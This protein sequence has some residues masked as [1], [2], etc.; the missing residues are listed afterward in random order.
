MSYFDTLYF[1]IVC[2]DLEF[3]FTMLF[4][5]SGFLHL[6]F[7]FFGNGL[8]Y[9]LI[10]SHW[11]L[12]ILLFVRDGFLCYFKIFIGNRFLCYFLLFTLFFSHAVW[13]YFKNVDFEQFYC[14][15]QIG[16]HTFYF[17]VGIESDRWLPHAIEKF[18]CKIQAQMNEFK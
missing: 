8:I 14:S 4:F 12:F 3:M 11:F 2:T 15:L 6:F 13:C 16:F 18:S 1:A 7:L 5:G 10:F 17:I 9:L